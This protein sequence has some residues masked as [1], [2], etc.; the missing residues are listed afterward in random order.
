MSESEPPSDAS[1]SASL[2]GEQGLIFD[3]APQAKRTSYMV[4]F[5]LMALGMLAFVA[6]TFR[7][8]RSE[9]RS[10]TQHTERV[11]I[12]DPTAPG[13]VSILQRAADMSVLALGRREVKQD[14]PQM[15]THMPVF[16]PGFKDYTYQ[17][18]DL[19]SS[20]PEYRAPAW[21][22]PTHPPLPTRPEVSQL[23]ERNT[24]RAAPEYQLT[25]KPSP[26]LASRW[27]PQTLPMSE[28]TNLN[29]TGIT[30]RTAISE[31]GQVLLSLPLQQT[32]A[33][34]KTVEKLRT[35]ISS[36]RFKPA[37]GAGMVWGDL[38]FAWETAAASR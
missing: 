25:L 31:T 16:Q 10:V 29:L 28:T 37:P 38:S 9:L 33:Q 13:V 5:S 27:K 20:P 32:S 35:A 30:F 11:L 36:L 6:V 4:L 19:P 15:A 2:S 7:V 22:R 23:P 26:P 17:L 34:S 24:P 21:I 14:E 1:S 12:L 3:W 8:E 18:K